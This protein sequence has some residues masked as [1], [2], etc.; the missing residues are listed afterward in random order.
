MYTAYIGR[1]LIE[2]LN[3]RDNLNA[4]R[5]QRTVRE[6]F[7]GEYFD[8]FF[9]D[10]RYL[11]HVNNSKF[12]QAYKQKAKSPLT[13]GLRAT[14]LTAQQNRIENDVPDGSFFLGGAAAESSAGTSGQVTDIQLKTTPDEV[15][16]SWIGAALGIGVSGGLNI[17]I[18]SDEVLLAL[19]DGWRQYRHYLLEMPN[20][21]PHQINTWNG[22]WLTNVFDEDFDPANLFARQPDVKTDKTTGGASLETQKWVGVLFALARRLSGKENPVA[23]VYALSQMNTTVGFIQIQLNQIVTVQRELRRQLFARRGNLNDESLDRLYNTEMGFQKACSMGAIG[24]QT[25]EP[26]S[27]REYMPEPAGKGKSFKSPKTPDD[28]LWITYIIYQTWLIAMLDNQKLLELSEQIAQMLAGITDTTNR[29]KKVNRNL[30]LSLVDAENRPEFIRQL[31]KL[32]D[33]APEQHELI[34]SVANTVTTLPIAQMPLFM[35]LLKLKFAVAEAKQKQ[36]V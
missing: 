15:Y 14:L 26:A 31:A 2:L 33:A 18:D 29:G 25:L 16:A 27:L 20:L 22:W 23:Y 12:D 10:E 28:E 6:F 11:Q 8:L 36:T 9:N 5:I 32:T 3:A 19:Y 4:G 17:L 30:V 13:P 35:A 1:R 34:D 24:I 7:E 21:K